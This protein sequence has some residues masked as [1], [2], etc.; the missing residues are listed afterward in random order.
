MFLLPSTSPKLRTLATYAASAIG[1]KL[2]FAFTNLI[3]KV[4]NPQFST[5]LFQP[6]DPSSPPSKRD[7][8]ETK[9]E[10]NDTSNQYNVCTN[11]PKNV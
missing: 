3:Y 1:A 4:I 5:H 6:V 9:Q 10:S 2:S 11:T 7:F 8:A